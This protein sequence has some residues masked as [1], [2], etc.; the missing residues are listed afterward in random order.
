MEA[1]NFSKPWSE[2]SFLDAVKDSHALYLTAWEDGKPAG[3]A[4]M[5]IA[6]DEGEITNVCVKQ[7]YRGRKIGTALLAPWN[8]GKGERGCLFLSGSEREQRKSHWI[9][10]KGRICQ[11]GYTKKFL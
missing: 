6:L 3:Y 10:R 7:E 9:V 11:N 4:G 2:K 5:W 1:E 8:R